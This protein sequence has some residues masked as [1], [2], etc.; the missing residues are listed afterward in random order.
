MFIF[1]LSRSYSSNDRTESPTNATVPLPTTAILPT[2]KK[3]Q[4]DLAHEKI[5][6]SIQS[7]AEGV[8]INKISTGLM[9]AQCYNSESES[10]DDGSEGK[11]KMPKLGK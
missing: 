10:D 7:K 3:L 4:L 11:P 5:K 1:K 9:L 6:A 8:E 2:S